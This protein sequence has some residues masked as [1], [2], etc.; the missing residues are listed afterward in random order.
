MF[1][2]ASPH[3][4]LALAALPAVA[5]WRRRR[6]PTPKLG[7]PAV[8]RFRGVARSPALK[9]RWV[10]PAIKVAAVVLLLAALARPQW[11]T[12]QTDILTR[13]INI[14]LAVD[15]SESMAAL[16][17]TR[18][19]KVVNRLEAVRGVI[20]AFVGGR[21]GD[22]IGLVVFGTNAYTQVPM[23][24]DYDAIDT[25]LERVDI[26]AA[27]NSTAVGDAIGIALKRLQDIESESNV[28]ILLTDGRSNAGEL[29]P[30]AAAEI[31]REMGVRVYT[32]GVGGR[33]RAPFLVKHPLLGERYVY[34]RVDIDEETLKAIAAKTGGAYFKAED[35]RQ[36]ESIYA[37][38]D[39][40]E[41]TEVKTRT[42]AEYRELYIYLLIPAIGCL[43][44]WCLLDN[45]RFLRVP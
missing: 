36:L 1:R 6:V 43:A 45:T 2:F 30:S 13:G 42:Y 21:N 14:V 16:D 9:L 29:T 32:V 31:A 8:D 39:R 22:R 12:R 17:F 33:G 18:G 28:V 35:T 37:A 11:G 19:D 10:V 44:L 7:V 27:G 15:V 24:R 26:G 20:R 23:T 3:F 41:R 5:V 40:M 38:I 4:L 25:I 34:R